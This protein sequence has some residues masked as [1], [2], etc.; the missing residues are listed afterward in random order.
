MRALKD[1]NKIEIDLVDLRWQYTFNN[2][3]AGY[4]KL[5]NERVLE[6]DLPQILAN[7][8]D[9]AHLIIPHNVA[10]GQFLPKEMVVALLQSSWTTDEDNSCGCSELVIAWFQEK[11]DPFK[12]IKKIVRKLDWSKHATCTYID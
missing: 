7:W 9:T 3:F 12:N 6:I 4:P 11:I 2:Y 8:K 5:I 10:D 1:K